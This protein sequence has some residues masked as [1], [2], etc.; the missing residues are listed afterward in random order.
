M[1]SLPCNR[2]YRAMQHISLPRLLGIAAL[3]A[4]PA[5]MAQ[6]ALPFV[7]LNDSVLIRIPAKDVPGFKSWIGQALNTGAPGSTLD[8]QSSHHARRAPVRVQVTPGPVTPTR[9]AGNCRLLSAQVEQQPRPVETW[10]V[11][12]CQQPDGSWKISTMG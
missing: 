4:V 1:P 11:W 8:W 5:G 10:K 9:T 2:H 6:A 3:V 12:F 7:Q